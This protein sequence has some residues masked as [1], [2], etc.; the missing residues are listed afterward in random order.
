MSSAQE[1][2][3]KIDAALRALNKNPEEVVHSRDYSIH[4]TEDGQKVSTKSRVN[5]NVPPIA[6]FKPTNEQLFLPS[7][8]PN[9]QFLKQHFLTRRSI[10]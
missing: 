10:D 7:G 2:S 4:I 9:I 6:N 1:N 3:E 5:N 8:I